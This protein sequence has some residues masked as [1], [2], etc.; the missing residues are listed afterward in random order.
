[1]L[2]FGAAHERAQGI[3]LDRA[4]GTWQGGREV[5]NYAS[6]LLVAEQSN[7]VELNALNVDLPRFGAPRLRPPRRLACRRRPL[8]LK[9]SPPN[10]LA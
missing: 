9:A 6:F 8:A 3:G 7:E 5:A 4:V 2:L 10:V 1:M